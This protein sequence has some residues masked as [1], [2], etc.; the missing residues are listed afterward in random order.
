M[1]HQVIKLFKKKK[2]A[3]NLEFNKEKNTVSFASAVELPWHG[4]GTVVPGVMTTAEAIE[5][6]N[7]DFTVTKYP[8][9]VRIPIQEPLYKADGTILKEGKY[10]FVEVADTFSTVRE[11][12][13]EILGTVGNMYTVLQNKDAFKFFD[14]ILEENEAFIETVGVL[15]KGERIFISAKLPDHI[16]IFGKDDVI[17]QYLLITSSHDGKSATTIMFTPIRVVCQ[18]TLNLALNK[19]TPN[20]VSVKHTENQLTRIHLAHEILGLQNQYRK[21]IEEIFGRLAE[22]KCTDEMLEKI[23][24]KGLSDNAGM[25]KTYF[26]KDAKQSTRFRNNVQA[27]MNY[28]YTNP[29]QLMPST[30][31][32]L[33]GAY[34]AV[35]GWYQNECNWKGDDDAKMRSIIDMNGRVNL[36][37]QQ[38]FEAAFALIK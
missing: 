31:E 12:N 7:L 1:F 32:T 28:A 22:T 17:E 30:K 9:Y 11:D 24:V 6:A 15:G 18:N 21:E 13:Q 25:V 4:L 3:H 27:V 34:N 38:T 19:Q 33:F 29:T 26:D 5:K 36:K 14:P 20:R 2:M 8:Q 16:T 37:Q 35:T 10:E 23:I